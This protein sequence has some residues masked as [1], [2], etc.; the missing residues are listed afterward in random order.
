MRVL[1]DARG[2]RA[3][4]TVQRKCLVATLGGAYKLSWKF[5]G[6]G[7]SCRHDNGKSSDPNPELIAHSVSWPLD[8]TGTLQ[9]DNQV[10]SSHVM[11]RVGPQ[12]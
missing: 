5:A 4:L 6:S 1:P 3:A 7:E 10:L 9:M 12:H 11:T 8:S 2:V